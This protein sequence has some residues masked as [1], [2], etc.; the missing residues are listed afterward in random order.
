MG[1]ES[2]C[3]CRVGVEVGHSGRSHGHVVVVSRE[4][5]LSNDSGRVQRGSDCR[6]SW[7]TL[8]AL[9]VAEAQQLLD[10]ER[11]PLW[12]CLRRMVR[13]SVEC[14]WGCYMDGGLGA[15]HCCG[16]QVHFHGRMLWDILGVAQRIADG[17]LRHLVVVEPFTGEG[18]AHTL[19][20]ALHAFSCALVTHKTFRGFLIVCKDSLPSQQCLSKSQCC[21][22]AQQPQ[23]CRR[24]IYLNFA[25]QIILFFNCKNN[26]L[27]FLNWDFCH[28]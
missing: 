18:I 6:H 7:A 8:P 15:R 19:F 22:I 1:Q 20:T 14:R 24:E 23:R 16:F 3:H 10:S 2:R 5:R 21:S 17:F 28:F 27:H 11:R 13:W 9:G 12:Q 26:S 4:G 25:A